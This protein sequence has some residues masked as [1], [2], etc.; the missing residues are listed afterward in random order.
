MPDESGQVRLNEAFASLIE[1]LNGDWL[2]GG[3][4]HYCAG[5]S[6][7]DG[8]E[9]SRQRFVDLAMQSLLRRMGLHYS[10]AGKSTPAPP[11]PGRV[12][13]FPKIPSLENC[14]EYKRPGPRYSTPSVQAFLK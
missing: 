7:C 12:S 3:L 4:V 14:K 13:L 10:I 9:G 5:M 2:S 11:G 8:V 1:F 6:C